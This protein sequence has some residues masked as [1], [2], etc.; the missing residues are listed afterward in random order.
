MFHGFDFHF[1]SFIHIKSTEL[2]MNKLKNILQLVLLVFENREE[3]VTL[4]RY[5]RLIKRSSLYLSIFF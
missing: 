3:I 1:V 4:I 2:I 5:H